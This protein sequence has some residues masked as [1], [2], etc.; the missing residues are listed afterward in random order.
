MKLRS[1]ELATALLLAA[2]VARCLSF[3]VTDNLDCTAANKHYD[4]N[5]FQCVDC[6]T[7]SIADGTTLGMPLSTRLQVRH[8]LLLRKP[9]PQT[10]HG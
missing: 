4:Q 10:C 9:R 6:F 5:T 2:V 8:Q 7:N 3:E 1:S